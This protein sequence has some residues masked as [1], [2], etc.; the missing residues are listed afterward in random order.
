MELNELRK[1]ID[2]IDS[3][4]LTLLSKRMLLAV[5][6]GRL[7]KRIENRIR[8]NEIF[9]S[10]KKR[11]D[12]LMTYS[13]LE[14]LYRNIMSESKKLE[15]DNLKLAGFQGEKGAFG[16]TACKT[17]N[18][19]LVPVP[20]VDF[21]NVFEG[22]SNGELDF[23]VVPIENSTEG[24]IT[25]VSHLVA[26]KDLN[27]VGEVHLPV[28]HSLLALSNVDVGDLKVVYSHPQALA[29]CRNFIST[30]KLEPRPYYDTAGAAAKIAK[31][32][33]VAAAAIAGR[34]CADLYGL[35]IVKENIEDSESNFTRF[36]ILSKEKPLGKGNKC[37][38]TF[39]T[40]DKVGALTSVLRIFK[41]AN[42]NLTMIES[43]P[44]RETPDAARFLIDFTGSYSD[45]RTLVALDKVRAETIG[46]RLLGCYGSWQK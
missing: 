36:L 10:L 39:S 6:A 28:R 20:C 1:E 18:G 32:K 19:S 34:I 31:E 12:S 43:V 46:F 25:S 23:G 33:Q 29:Q 26:E 42:I 22:V 11:Q 15:G 37:S 13:F 24:A 2:Q 7:K 30:N 45:K 41:E 16:E 21:L 38:I 44:S 5:R 27:I 14:K 9:E 17:F 40:R 3:E 8:E 4:I 35:K